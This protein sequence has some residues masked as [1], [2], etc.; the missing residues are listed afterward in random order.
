MKI[1]PVKKQLKKLA[2]L[3]QLNK[4]KKRQHQLI[5][6]HLTWN[7]QK[8]RLFNAVSNQKSKKQ[9]KNKTKNILKR[10]I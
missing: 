9:Q 2:K 4:S 7:Q 6:R 3:S 10:G 8:Q 5:K 1:H